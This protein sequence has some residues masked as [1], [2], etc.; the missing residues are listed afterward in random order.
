MHAYYTNA[1]YNP[2]RD[3]VLIY[4]RMVA[5]SEV[6]PLTP[7]GLC[8]GESPM[9]GSERV[10]RLGGRGK[11]TMLDD[12]MRAGPDCWRSDAAADEG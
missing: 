8:A 9:G 2:P 11:A 7:V 3:G 12:V 10:G 4:P 5:F 6:S 1:I